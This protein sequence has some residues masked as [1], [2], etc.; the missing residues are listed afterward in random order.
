MEV[1]ILGSLFIHPHPQ[2]PPC[3]NWKAWKKHETS[4][5]HPRNDFWEGIIYS[6]KKGTHLEFSHY[7]LNIISI[8]E[9][10]RIV[11][12]NHFVGGMPVLTMTF[13]FAMVHLGYH[14]CLWWSRQ[15]Q[16]LASVQGWWHRGS[17][18]SNPHGPTNTIQEH[19]GTSKSLRAAVVHH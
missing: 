18:W 7:R 17:K 14:G 19:C 5:K 16:M 11:F 12:K 6:S 9:I 10:I 4:T 15:F 13:L 3:G 1:T 2:S 8:R